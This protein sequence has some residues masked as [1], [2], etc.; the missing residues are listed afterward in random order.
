[1]ADALDLFLTAERLLTV[2]TEALDDQ[3]PPLGLEGAPERRYVSPGLPAFDCP[4][5]LTVHIPA[6]TEELTVPLSPQ[7]ATGS[8]QK[9]R[10]RINLVNFVVTIVR[11]APGMENSGVFP[12]VDEEESS[13]EQV[14]ADGWCLWVTI[15][16]LAM[17]GDLFGGDVCQV[18]RMSSS[19]SLD[20]M[21]GTV[22][23][24]INLQTE[25]DGYAAVPLG[26]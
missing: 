22:G 18:R 6:L 7:P 12:T 3:L 15:F 5:Q 20:P 8:R 2:C 21:G 1:M 17:N 25:L 11:C 26:G 13:A 16:R 14:M 4:T 19:P 23:W 9:A 10:G 24:T